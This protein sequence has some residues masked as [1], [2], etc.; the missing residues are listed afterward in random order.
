MAKKWSS[1]ALKAAIFGM[2]L[3]AAAPALAG[4][5]FQVPID[6]ARPL[7]LKAAATGVVVGNP[8]IAGVTLQ[9]DKLLFITGKAYGTT[10]LIIVGEGGR[11]I[12]EGLVTVTGDDSAGGVL[13][14]TRGL[15]TVRQSCN[16]VCR[17]TPEISDD[18]AAF[19]ELNAQVTAH[20][21]RAGGGGK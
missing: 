15:T 3:A 16:P 8:S 4:T 9:S 20:A 12:Y 7:S 5:P 2:A 18:S 14:V 13:T 17:K 6:Q 11:P 19:D 1:V 10:N 21:A